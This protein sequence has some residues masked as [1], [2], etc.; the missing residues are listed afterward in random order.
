MSSLDRFNNHIKAKN[1]I[2]TITEQLISEYLIELKNNEINEDKYESEL[3][4]LNSVLSKK[5]KN[6]V[7][8]IRI[9]I[10]YPKLI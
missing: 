8:R 2:I 9:F 5:F 6:Q 7:L 3:F 4:L 10:L 1:R